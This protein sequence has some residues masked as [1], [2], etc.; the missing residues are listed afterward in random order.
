MKTR[1]MLVVCASAILLVILAGGVWRVGPPISPLT[2]LNRSAQATT[3]S[4]AGRPDVQIGACS[5]GR[6][7]LPSETDWEFTS[8]RQTIDS[9]RLTGSGSPRVV[10]LTVAHDGG[11]GFAVDIPGDANAAPSDPHPCAG[12]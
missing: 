1:L 11:V 5:F 9:Q 10:T 8:G 2:I 7:D 12:E 3:L 6:F 4:V